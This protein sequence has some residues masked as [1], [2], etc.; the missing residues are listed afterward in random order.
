VQ[1]ALVIGIFFDLGHRAIVKKDGQRQKGRSQKDFPGHI[2][3][4]FLRP[5]APPKS[6]DN[7]FIKIILINYSRKNK[8]GKKLAE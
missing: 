4:R 2:R 8:V 7:W 3:S 6:M 1:D 5:P